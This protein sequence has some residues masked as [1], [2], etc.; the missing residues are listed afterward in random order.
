MPREYACS[1]CGKLCTVKLLREPYG[2]VHCLCAN[3]G[4][5]DRNYDHM[6]LFH[7]YTEDNTI[8][9]HSGYSCIKVTTPF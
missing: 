1:Q 3:C 5:L 8:A 9:T 7:R 4:E 2:C 6:F